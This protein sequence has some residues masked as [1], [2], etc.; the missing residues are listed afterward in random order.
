MLIVQQVYIRCWRILSCKD[1]RIP[2]DASDSIANWRYCQIVVIVHARSTP[3][4][5]AA[6][7]DGTDEGHIRRGDLG[8]GG[9]IRTGSKYGWIANCS[10]MTIEDA[11]NGKVECYCNCAYSYAPKSPIARLI[12]FRLRFSWLGLSACWRNS[13]SLLQCFHLSLPRALSRVFLLLL[14]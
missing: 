5:A 9:W 7:I 10:P 14:R 4:K 12:H 8:R 2:I 6:C 13:A 3:A 11:V 1:R